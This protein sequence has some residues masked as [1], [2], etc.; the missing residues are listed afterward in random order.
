MSFRRTLLAALCLAAVAPGA[1][2]AGDV[3]VVQRDEPLGAVRS[4]L[5]RPAPVEF[6]MI[7]VHWQGAGDVSFRTA[8]A[9]GGWSAW[10]AARP[11]E[12]DAPDLA[13]P[14]GAASRAWKVGNP[15]WTGEAS[16]IQY[17]VSGSVTRLRAFFVWS[18]VTAA[19]AESVLD[20]RAPSAV[21]AV[22][23]EPDRPAMIG[24]PG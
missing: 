5:A 13:S 7:G 10:R 4:S 8:A 23:A 17:R 24:R 3:R 20:L 21:E 22:A 9:E 1:A 12:E 11:E 15:W 6:T 2:R 19:H 14:E 16:R 18:P